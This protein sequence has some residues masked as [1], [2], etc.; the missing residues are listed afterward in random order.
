MHTTKPAAEIDEKRNSA[1]LERKTQ[2]NTAPNTKSP[3]DSKTVGAGSQSNNEG[4]TTGTRNVVKVESLH[5]NG[6]VPQQEVESSTKSSKV[7]VSFSGKPNANQGR[8]NGTDTIS[9]GDQK[10]MK[11]ES[12]SGKSAPAGPS[13]KSSVSVN[14]QSMQNNSVNKETSV[15][16]VQN[17]KTAQPAVVKADP[18]LAKSAA[19]AVVY[20]MG[21]PVSVDQNLGRS[22]DKMLDEI[23]NFKRKSEPNPDSRESLSRVAPTMSESSDDKVKKEPQSD[24]RES[25]GRVAPTV[26]ESSDDKV[27]KEPQSVSSE[28]EVDS[29]SGSV[30]NSP[31]AEKFVSSFSF[32]QKSQNAPV[33]KVTSTEENKGRTTPAGPTGKGKWR[34]FSS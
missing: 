22:R 24:S 25:L 14:P 7:T 21:R 13:F 5:Q 3:P 16:N 34:S 26:S 23:R 19:P 29:G 27:K 15:K 6:S 9:N 12:F 1:D 2:T 11:T 4:I 17:S 8:V 30:E 18:K 28:D 10:E 32:P 20:H 33:K 31:K